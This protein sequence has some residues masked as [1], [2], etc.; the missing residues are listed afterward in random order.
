MRF[1]IAELTAVETLPGR[2]AVIATWMP[3]CR[4]SVSRSRNTAYHG[5][6]AD[7]PSKSLRKAGK[8][9]TSSRMRG[10]SG[11]PASARYSVIVDAFTAE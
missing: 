10:S 9:S 7:V 6:V 2:S 1:W 5:A 8:P 3:T 4:A 11:L